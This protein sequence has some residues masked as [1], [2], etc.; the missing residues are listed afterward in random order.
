MG[1]EMGRERE[2]SKYLTV[3]H[4][5]SVSISVSISF[6]VPKSLTQLQPRGLNTSLS[7]HLFF[8]TFLSL[9]ISRH[10][11]NA[12]LVVENIFLVSP[13]MRISLK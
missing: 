3:C 12:E 9:H 7:S 11:Y 6:S 5:N 8:Y 10:D 2:N 13:P 1:K 4:E